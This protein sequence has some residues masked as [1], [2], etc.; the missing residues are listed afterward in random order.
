VP[1]EVAPLADAQ[2]V[3]AIFPGYD[4]QT[5]ATEDPEVHVAQA[6][7]HRLEPGLFL[8]LVMVGQAPRARMEFY[9][10]GP[11]V[12]LVLVREAPEGL[13]VTFR[14]TPCAM[15]Y[16]NVYATWEEAQ[17]DEPWACKLN[18]Q[19]LELRPGEWALSITEEQ[20]SHYGNADSAHTDVTLYRRVE[21]ALEQLL[22]VRT[23][24]SSQRYEETTPTEES[25]K[26]R[27]GAEGR[28]GFRD[29]EVVREERDENGQWRESVEAV[30]SW[31][32]VGY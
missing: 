29:I 16:D 31:N 24:S 10:G 15:S 4:A 9:T 7:V 11:R 1:A 27:A 22:Q 32:G 21:D 25:R 12:E 26:L 17:R 6:E 5:G 28:D 20:G 13:G 3:A 8:A 30:H 2:V 18:L 14:A 19:E 23:F